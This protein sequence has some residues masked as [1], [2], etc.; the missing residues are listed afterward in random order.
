MNY[1]KVMSVGMFH[2]QHNST[3]CVSICYYSYILKLNFV[4]ALS[5]QLYRA[6]S[7]FDNII[8]RISEELG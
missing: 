7:T 6:R 5:E 3:E 1:E 4:L 2:L 8:Y